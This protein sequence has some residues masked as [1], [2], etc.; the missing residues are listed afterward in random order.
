M[1]FYTSYLAKSHKC[2]NPVCI[3]AGTPRFWQGKVYSKLGPSFSLLN[4]YKAGKIDNLGY[5]KVFNEYLSSLNPET[6]V[7]ELKALFEG[8][9]EITLLCYEGP[10]KFCHRHLVA[11]WLTENGYPAREF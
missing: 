1:Q 9:E 2:P 11:K 4:D 3:T 7:N 10:G 6:V 8:E 5:T